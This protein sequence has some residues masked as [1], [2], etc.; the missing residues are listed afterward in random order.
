MDKINRIIKHHVWREALSQIEKLEETRI[1]CKHN[2]EHFLSV[3]RIAQLENLEKNL[4]FSKE[5]IYST[6]LL[7]DIGRGLQY[8]EGIPHDEASVMIAEKILDDCGFDDEEK[9]EIIDAILSHRIGGSLETEAVSEMMNLKE[10]IYRADKLSRNCFA[11][12]A[13]TECNWQEEKKN[14]YLK[15]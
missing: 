9:H 8:T 7:H 1:F 15:K 13:E 12:A 4:G 6:A 3:A 11:C 10:L 5:L 14:K 2:L